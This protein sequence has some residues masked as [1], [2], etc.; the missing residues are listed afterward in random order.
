MNILRLFL[1]K[2]WNLNSISYSPMPINDVKT[3]E[4]NLRLY[5]V[6]I[7]NG[8]L[9]ASIPNP[10]MYIIPGVEK[11]WQQINSNKKTTEHI[12]FVF[13]FTKSCKTILY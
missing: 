9:T 12:D 11:V 13:I 5:I 1:K 8:Y 6:Y 10:L 4:F 2:K 3:L 7:H